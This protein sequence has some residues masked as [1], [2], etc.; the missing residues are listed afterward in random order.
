MASSVF[1]SNTFLF[2][3]LELLIIIQIINK[4]II[5]CVTSI[6]NCYDTNA[7][8]SGNNI[9]DLVSTMDAVLAKLAV[10]LNVNKLSL[11]IDKTHYLVFNGRKKVNH[12]EDML[13]NG[14]GSYSKVL[15]VIC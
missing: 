5:R 10:W 8:L 12:N 15:G 11:N 7:F 9:S 2:L 4:N 1:S 13:I 3:L 14:K 6:Y